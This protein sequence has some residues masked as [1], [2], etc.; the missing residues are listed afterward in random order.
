MEEVEITK[1]IPYVVKS[2]QRRI[3]I[4]YDDEADVL[5]L[6]FTYPPTAVEHEE[7]EDGIVRNY[8]AAGNLTGLT[9]L[10]AKRFLE[11]KTD[12]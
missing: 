8:D 3:W 5:Y 7:D 12:E 11:A 4:H 9:I 1:I 6:N 2:A 10:A